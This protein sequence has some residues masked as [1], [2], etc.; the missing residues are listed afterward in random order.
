MATYQTQPAALT[1]AA[2]QDYAEMVGRHHGIYSDD[3]RADI[4]TLISRL[5]GRV[6]VAT[7]DESLQVRGHGDFTIFIPHH[8][9]ARRDRFTKAHEL[10]HY[11]LHYLYPKV[12]GEQCF[13]RG[14]RDRAETEANVFASALLMPA[15]QFSLAFKRAS[16]DLWELATQFDVSPRAAEVRAEVLGLK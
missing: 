4:E 9:S 13:G 11:F 16:G 3:G 15:E 2:V 6:D 1:N 5:G 12:A 14:G 7:G 10:G 8:T